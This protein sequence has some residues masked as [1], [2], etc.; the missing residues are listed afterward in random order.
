MT[1]VPQSTRLG[2]WPETVIGVALIVIL[3]AVVHGLTGWQP[4][5]SALYGALVMW[6]LGRRSGWRAAHANQ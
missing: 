6:V 5:L 4:D 2:H 3:V 1:D